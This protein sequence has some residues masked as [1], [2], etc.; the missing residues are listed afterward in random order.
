MIY[1][2]FLE[3]SVKTVRKFDFILWYVLVTEDL[4]RGSKSY[5]RRGFDGRQ[6]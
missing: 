5:V 3:L 1:K 4:Y 6:Y 2:N